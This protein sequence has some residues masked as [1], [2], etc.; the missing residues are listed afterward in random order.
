MFKMIRNTLCDFLLPFRA[1][2]AKILNF[3]SS[4]LIKRRNVVLRFFQSVNNSTI[5]KQ[6]Y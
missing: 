3:S 2:L 1:I 5:F 4:I 6:A